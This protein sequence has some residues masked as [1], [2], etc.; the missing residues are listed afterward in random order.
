MARQVCYCC[1][2][3]GAFSATVS[4]GTGGLSLPVYYQASISMLLTISMLLLVCSDLVR[5]AKGR[6]MYDPNSGVWS[7]NNPYILCISV[8]FNSCFKI[9]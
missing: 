4:H 2:N 3:Y 1:T 6:N 7:N 8:F 9:I 5:G